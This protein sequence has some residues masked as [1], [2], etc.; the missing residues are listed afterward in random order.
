[1]T[2]RHVG[3]ERRPALEELHD[4]V[5]GLGPQLRPLDLGTRLEP[6][7]ETVDALTQPGQRLVDERER[8][9]LATPVDR[10][11]D[12][13]VGDRASGGGHRPGEVAVLLGKEAGLAAHHHA[14]AVLVDE[15]VLAVGQEGKQ[16]LEAVVERPAQF[17]AQHLVEAGS[18][19]A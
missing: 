12:R 14:E 19:L 4:P 16:R 15:E 9:R 8:L 6:V 17:V 18:L 1:M 3:L 13:L 10:E 5:V 11:L 2:G 7:A